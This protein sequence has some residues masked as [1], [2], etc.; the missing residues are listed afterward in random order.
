M[1]KNQE[2][3]LQKLS[4]G[5]DATD[6]EILRLKY[7]NPKI[8][9]TQIGA[10]LGMSK[11]GVH[12]RLQKEKV[13][14]AFEWFEKD[15]LFQLKS[16]QTEAVYVYSQILKS[17]DEKLKLQAA[18]DILNQVFLSPHIGATNTEDEILEFINET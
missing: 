3:E 4:D 15:V 6:K 17:K 16:M 5:L 10:I 7:T 13:K 1:D 14:K 12:Y 9:L 2:E 11:Q 8:S 18:K